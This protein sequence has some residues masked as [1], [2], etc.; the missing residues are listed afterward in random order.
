MSTGI[1]D[2]NLFNRYSQIFKLNPHT[3]CFF[4]IAVKGLLIP[5]P[6]PTNII[7][8]LLFLNPFQLRQSEYP[9][10]IAS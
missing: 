4:K 5:L 2:I 9:S 3:F 6:C 7:L 8:K 1:S 10:L